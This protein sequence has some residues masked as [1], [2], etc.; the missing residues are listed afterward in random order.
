MLFS[1]SQ[2]VA[3]QETD[4]HPHQATDHDSAWLSAS[5]T[6]ILKSPAESKAGD[7]GRGKGGALGLKAQV[8]GSR[9]D[10]GKKG[11]LA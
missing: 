2:K 11:P 3:S 10:A 6:L 1:A 5:A 9:K 7:E 8:K 4:T